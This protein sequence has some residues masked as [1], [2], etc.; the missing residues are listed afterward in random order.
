MSKKPLEVLSDIDITDLKSFVYRIGPE[1]YEDVTLVDFINVAVELLLEEN[2][3]PH[4]VTEATHQIMEL[5]EKIVNLINIKRQQLQQNNLD[6]VIHYVK[7]LQKNGL[8]YLTIKL[9]FEQ[10][11]EADVLPKT[12]RF[13]NDD[14]DTGDH[15]MLDDLISKIINHFKSSATSDSAPSAEPAGST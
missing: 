8:E 15:Q 12:I 9:I 4:A 10:L 3:D 11:S 7:D 2:L 5:A 14:Y 13:E 6:M 1:L